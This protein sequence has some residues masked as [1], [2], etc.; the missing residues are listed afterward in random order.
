MRMSGRN[1]ARQR[2]DLVVVEQPGLGIGAVGPLLEHL[3]GD[4]R[5]EAVG[6]VPTG[7]EG[8]AE[9]PLVAERE[10]QA[11]P[12]VVAEVVDVLRS[13][14][15]ERRRLD[16]VGEH[17]P[18]G[19]EVGVDAGV[20]LDVGVGRAEEGFGV[21]GGELLD[22]VDVLAPGV[23]AVADRA[24]GVLVGQPRAHREQHR[25]RGVV[26]AGDELQRAA[27]V[28]QLGADGPGDRRLDGAD[29]LQR[30]AVGDR[31]CVG[32]VACS[33]AL[34]D[35]ADLVDAA[36]VPAAVE[37]C[38]QP[39]P[40]DLVGEP[41]GDDAAADGSTLASLCSRLRRAV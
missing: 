13:G 14:V 3:A 38:R 15:G 17:G 24:L 22:G 18:E 11:R 31:C 25:R 41:G 37:R 23:E 4:V 40:E 33:G 10:A 8:H 30:A 2:G 6:Q 1:S 7:V 20:R 34:L 29:D 39:Q 16:P 36:L 19:D 21:V 9:H 35:V 27:L 32:V 26:L 28:G 5:A 12:V